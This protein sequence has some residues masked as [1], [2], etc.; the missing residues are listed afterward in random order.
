MIAAVI[1]TA[2]AAVVGVVGLHQD[3]G[4]ALA[5]NEQLR[6]IYTLGAHVAVAKSALEESPPQGGRALEEIQAARTLY[7]I[8]FA[9][10]GAAAKL[11]AALSAA[12]QRLQTNLAS[13]AQV[14]EPVYAELSD[15]SSAT[16]QT[17][18]A[19]QASADREHEWTVGA[20]VALGALTTLFAIGV[21]LRQYRAIMTPLGQLQRTVQRIASGQLS[22]R[23][24]VDGDGEF[25]L[26][27]AEFNRMAG[28]LQ[29][30][31]ADLEQR[32]QAKSRELVQSERLASV[33]Y[34]AAG[35]AH[36]INNPLAIIAGYGERALRRLEGLEDSTEASRG[37]AA[38]ARQAIQIMCDQAFRCKQITD[39]L[40]ML[41]RP[42]ESA[43]RPLALAR[44]AQDV[45][46]SVGGLARFSDR[47]LTLEADI[48]SDLS[49]VGNEGELRQ[50]VLNLVINALEAAPPETGQVQL[51]VRR[52]GGE[53]ELT[54]S[55]NGAGMNADTLARVFE[56]FFSK[57]KGER[58]GTGLGL[59]I[60]HAIIAEHGGRIEAHSAGVG[61]GSRFVV[62]L[63][64]EVGELS[65]VAEGLGAGEVA[66]GDRA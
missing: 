30:V 5:A 14:L 45:M 50:T 53:I 21:G 19:R 58:P 42:G 39:H 33:G 35:V 60:A 61:A 59:S 44:V 62:R 6:Q 47:R 37:D 26:L 29:A 52:D 55:D 22:D 63:P 16:R 9:D 27:A 36:E 41:A 49:V 56:P 48:D 24:P 66:H 34:L 38:S 12:A 28:E 4:V 2:A 32:V 57:K 18:A 11:S 3:F 31:Q 13:D 51:R 64:A 1:L 65:R 43:R 23:A 17:I 54:V 10:D 40:L 25:R 46:A 15:L 7:D 20:V 8:A